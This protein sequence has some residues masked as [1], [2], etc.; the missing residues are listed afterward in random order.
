M[1]IKN[2]I[3]G[4]TEDWKLKINLFTKLFLIL[5]KKQVGLVNVYKIYGGFIKETKH[6]EI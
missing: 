4:N 1:I 2:Q 3:E 5:K 6:F